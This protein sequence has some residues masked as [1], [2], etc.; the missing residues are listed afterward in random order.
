MRFVNGW[1]KAHRDLR[2]KLGLFDYAV[3]MTIISWANRED[4]TASFGGQTITVKRGQLLTSLSELSD[5]A[6][7]PYLHRIRS[8][9]TRLVDAEYIQ[10]AKSNDRRNGG[11]L[12]TVLNYDDLTGSKE[13]ERTDQSTQGASK[14]QHIGEREEEKNK[15]IGLSPDLNALYQAY[16]K[17]KGSNRKTKGLEYLAKKIKTQEQYDS[18]LRAIKNYA[19]ECEASKK[20]G[21]E[22]V[23]QFATF[24]NG[25]WE[26]YAETTLINPAPKKLS[27]EESLLELDKAE[28]AYNRMTLEEFYRFR[29]RTGST[30]GAT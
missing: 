20:T 4:T 10:Q 2:E 30:G 12:I 3:Y 15:Y 23:M 7:D 16:P 26:E 14:A 28:A 8:S 24:A 13:V 27:V 22:F 6:I 9:L 17:R 18:M 19:A 29:G 1:V 5:E 25:V 11:T 21:T